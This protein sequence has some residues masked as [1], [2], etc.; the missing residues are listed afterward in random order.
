[1]M[2]MAAAPGACF[3]SITNFGSMRMRFGSNLAPSR[4]ARLRIRISFSRCSSIH[5]SGFRSA[6]QAARAGSFGRFGKEGRE[7]SRTSEIQRWS[8]GVSTTLQHPVVTNFDVSR[9]AAHSPDSTQTSPIVAP[10]TRLRVMRATV[11]LR[12]VL[13]VELEIVRGTYFL[14]FSEK[15]RFHSIG[16]SRSLARFV[17]RFIGLGRASGIR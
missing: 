8:H 13:V 16:C 14:R 2:F 12:T 17:G 3:R 10:V 4:S 15:R 7:Q 9:T 1:M 11:G 5:E 6:I